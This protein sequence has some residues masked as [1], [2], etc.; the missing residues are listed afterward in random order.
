MLG[1]IHTQ[2]S[3]CR[4]LITHSRPHSFAQEIPPHT[5]IPPDSIPS[6]SAGALHDRL[7]N[8]GSRP[9]VIDVRE[10]REFKQGHIPESQLI[11]L[12][13]LVT[14]ASELS[15]DN[16][17]VLV[18]RSGPRSTRAAHLLRNKGHRHVCVLQGG[19]LAWENAGLLEAVELF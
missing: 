11:P 2:S 8:G 14:A 10:P 19:I 3:K 13:E 5:E 1:V 16:E 7:H 4:S 6:I 9:L 15:P 12:P 17:I 18:C